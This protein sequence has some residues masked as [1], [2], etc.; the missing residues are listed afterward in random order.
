MTIFGPV[1]PYELLT[2][3]RRGRH[4]IVRTLYGAVLLAT[5]CVQYE[6]TY[7]RTNEPDTV[8]AMAEFAAQFFYSFSIVQILAVLALTPAM[9]AGTI[10]EEKD[11]KTIE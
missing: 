5:L 8:E 2:S 10:A 1:L 11:R 6:A 4:F 3:S 7:R 9:V